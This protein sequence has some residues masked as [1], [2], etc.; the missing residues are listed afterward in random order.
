MNRLLANGNENRI[1]NGAR[2]SPN[3]TTKMKYTI[4]IAAIIA[5]P[6]CV[7]VSSISAATPA[8]PTVTPFGKSSSSIASSISDVALE[9]SSSRLYLKP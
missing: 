8:T 1:A 7:N 4:A 2:P 6:S 5:I 9:I 3:V